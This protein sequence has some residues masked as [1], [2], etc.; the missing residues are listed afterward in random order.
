[1]NNLT[2]PNYED[3]AAAAERIKDFINKTPV[4]TSRTVNNEFEAEV[5]FKCENFQRVGAFKFR[6]AMNALLQFSETQKKAGVVAFSSGNHAQAIALSSKILGIPATIIMPKDA[7]A[8]K[9]AATREYGGNIVEFDRY[10]EDREKIGK[11]I[12]EKNGLTLIPSYDHPHVI[13]GQG[14][15][16]KELFEEVGDLDYLFVC[17]GGGGLLAGSALSAR[18]LSPNC[19]IYGVEPALGNDGQMSFRKGEI[20]HIDTPPTIADGAQTQYLGKLTFPIIQQKVDDI[21]TATDEELI[22]AMKFFAER[23]KMVV[24]PTGC[25]GFA[26]ARNL[27]DEL[28]GKRIGIIIS[29]GNVDI[30]K[31]AEFLSA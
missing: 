8:A 16:A 30:S 7:P 3:V 15:A 2:L 10:T 13:A 14:T 9:M 17:L 5:F 21:L 20:V 1:M 22:N 6:G 25:L 26:A 19:K 23:M 4:L 31:Y 29:G 11:E 24:E 28:K 27:K 12:A 18:Q